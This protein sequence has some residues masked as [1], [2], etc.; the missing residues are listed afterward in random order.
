MLSLFRQIGRR[1]IV[2]AIAAIVF[3]FNEASIFS[4]MQFIASKQTTPHAA[5]GLRLA[6]WWSSFSLGAMI[7]LALSQMLSKSQNK[8]GLLR[9]C[10][11]EVLISAVCLLYLCL[12]RPAPWLL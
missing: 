7:G 10:M 4:W 5:Y 1:R 2:F 3:A 11:P 12:L 6:S 8:G 9:V